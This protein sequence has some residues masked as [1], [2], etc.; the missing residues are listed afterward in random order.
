MSGN[1]RGRF[2]FASQEQLSSTLANNDL[3]SDLAR[4]NAFPD[5][6]GCIYIYE[7]RYLSG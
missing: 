5:K 1:L 6:W 3:P 7:G 4:P 2:N